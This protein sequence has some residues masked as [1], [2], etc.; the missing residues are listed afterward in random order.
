MDEVIGGTQPLSGSWHQ[1]IDDDNV[2]CFGD[3]NRRLVLT[4]LRHLF[5]GSAGPYPFAR[6][7]VSVCRTSTHGIMRGVILSPGL[8]V[9]LAFAQDIPHQVK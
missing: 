9:A 4:W 5:V 7:A 2:L 1:S 6:L 8:D 3:G